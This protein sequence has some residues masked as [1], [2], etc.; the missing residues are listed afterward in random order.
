MKIKI[1]KNVTMPHERL[2][3][4]SAI[5]KQM[6]VGDSILVDTASEAAALVNTINR[7]LAKK[8]YSC[9]A[10]RRVEGGVRVWRTAPH[11]RRENK[12][13]KKA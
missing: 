6:K 4:W 13:R 3:Q 1:E 9:A 5:V 8:G 10:R 2:G 11:K 7:L 12:R